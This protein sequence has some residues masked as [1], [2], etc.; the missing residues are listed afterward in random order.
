MILLTVKLDSH[1]TPTQQGYM[2]G[3]IQHEPLFHHRPGHTHHPRL[4]WRGGSTGESG[5]G[6]TTHLRSERDG[7]RFARVDDPWG[8]HSDPDRPRVGTLR[9]GGVL[10]TS[11]KVGPCPTDGIRRGPTAGKWALSVSSR[12]VQMESVL[13]CR[14]VSGHTRPRCTTRTGHENRRRNNVVAT[15]WGGTQRNPRQVDLS[16]R[17]PPQLPLGHSVTP[18][19]AEPCIKSATILVELKKI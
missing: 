17:L 4:D 7:G 1:S 16:D 6:G 19:P 10:N 8:S 18:G 15:H 12:A 2:L 5:P 13:L 3:R 14:P 9:G 11:R